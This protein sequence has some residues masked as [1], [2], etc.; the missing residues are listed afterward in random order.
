VQAK[1]ELLAR[2]A[3]M[4]SRLAAAVRLRFTRVRARVEAATS[5][6]VFAAER[7]RLRSQA[8][9]VDELV[10][11]AESGL[12]RGVERARERFRRDRDRL[13]AFRWDRQVAGRRER[14]AR[15]RDRLLARLR[16]DVEVRRTRL[17]RLAAK[18]DGL[19]PLAVLSRGYALVWDAEG[20]RLLRDTAAVAVGDGLSVRLHAG[21]LAATVTAKEP[22]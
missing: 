1:E 12:R 4:G 18:L 17:G 15:Q 8:Q 22:A 13:E 2:I 21:T 3:A 14:L 6:R 7:G 20:H 10:R 19:S 9:R 11:R 5:H 16:S